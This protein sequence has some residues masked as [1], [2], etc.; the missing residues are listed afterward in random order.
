MSEWQAILKDRSV[1]TLDAL[2]ARFGSEVI[3]TEALGPAF[4]AFQMRITPAVLDQIKAVGDAMWQ[5]YVPTIQELDVVD[6]V[7]DS[8]DE[9]GDS[10]V[11]NITHRYPDRALFLVSPVCASYCRF[12]TRRRKVG[13][14][15][16][17]PLNQYDSAF[18]YLRSHPEI[19]DVILSGG[20]PMMLSDRRLEYLFE[21][22]REIPHIEII[23]IGSRI[24]SHLPERI[25]PEF[26][27]MVQ[28]YHPIFMNTHFN[29]PD[30]LT[31]AAVEALDRL[32]KAGVPLGCQT[33][34]LKGVND[35]PVVMKELMHRL[36]KARVR[37]Y[38]IYMCDPVA[39]G[40]H[41]R[42]TV[43]K[44]LEIIEA[45]RGWTSGLAVPHFVIDAPGG[46]GK[47]PLQPEYVESI[48]DE[49]VVFHN[50]EG[51]RFVYKQPRVAAEVKG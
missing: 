15:E 43:Q 13:D 16:K 40:E 30:E 23:R 34:L 48:T 19:R 6:G 11:P 17:I 9:D 2:A 18:A 47:V 26:C 25:T 22:L 29:H 45:L 4:D 41:F 44:G 38:Y 24:T 51:K 21:K 7:V 36:L 28:R 31:P 3:D 14:P 5:Q 39:G 35:D 50:Y 49:E 42:T 1:A 33:V 10:P 12:C 46:G 8:L 37:P 27:A 20:D 32:S